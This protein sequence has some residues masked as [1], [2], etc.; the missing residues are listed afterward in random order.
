MIITRK[1]F[2]VKSAQGMAIM[3]LPVL[4]SSFLESCNQQTTS[5]NGSS[6]P[7]PTIQGTISNG[8]VT[9]NIT[10]SSAIAK[11]GSA[12]IILYSSGSFLVDHPSATVY[13]AFTTVCPHQ[14]CAIDSFDSGSNQFV[15]LCHGSRFD[16]NGK[17]VQGPASSALQQ[18]QTQF[19]NN[20]L[21]I[22]L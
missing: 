19:T 11:V 17:V 8:T 12:G 4:F 13:N 16:I 7:L 2:F 6:S 20:Q 1:E 9:V 18:Y 14:G 10:S 22:T 3:S 15:C 5:P 21:I